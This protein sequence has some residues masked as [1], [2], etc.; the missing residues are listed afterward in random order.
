MKVSILGAGAIGSW[1][2]GRLAYHCPDIEVL[3]FARGDH[4]D[5][6][7]RTGKVTLRHAKKCH[8]VD[9]TL[10]DDIAELQGSDVV[11]LAVKSQ[12]TTAAMESALPYLGDAVL[13][14][15]QNGINQ[16]TLANYV[17]EDRLVM[18]MTATNMAIVE[19]GTVD[20][21]RDG[22]TVI[23][24][25][26]KNVPMKNTWLASEVLSKSRMR[27]VVEANVLGAQYNKLA[28]NA[29]GCA[30][31]LSASNI[32]S[33]GILNDAWRAAIAWPLHDECTSILDSAGIQVTR[34]AS[35]SDVTRFRRLLRLLDRPVAGAVVKFVAQSF[36]NP[37]PILF[38]VRVDLQHGK[39][40]E[41]DSLNGQFVRLADQIGCRAPYNRKVVELVHQLEGQGPGSFLTRDEVVAQFARLDANSS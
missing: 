3:F 29:L 7:R 11:L 14:S 16:T 34:T 31:A 38:S 28:F 5:H 35:L 23:G 20:L 36:F 2:G 26:H 6:L 4:G 17:R 19:P 13:V 15:I 27:I 22:P 39:P 30:S 9:V 40:T 33:E 24:P 25:P 18:G 8:Q 12:A 21:Q 32:I 37:R 1:Y 41:V 10:A